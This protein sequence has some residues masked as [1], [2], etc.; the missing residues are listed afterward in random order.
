METPV[1]PEA[2]EQSLIWKTCPCI[3]YGVFGLAPGLQLY[4]SIVIFK[5]VSAATKEN[6]I[7]FSQAVLEPQ[8]TFK[9]QG[10]LSGTVFPKELVNPFN[11]FIEHKMGVLLQPKGPEEGESWASTKIGLRVKSRTFKIRFNTWKPFKKMKMASFFNEN[12]SHPNK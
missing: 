1:K 10:G 4:G 11:S 8:S 3:P 2:V 9:G 6:Q 12:E 7:L 5:L